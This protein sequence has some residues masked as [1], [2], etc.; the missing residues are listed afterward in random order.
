MRLIARGE[1]QRH[2]GSTPSTK[3]K[4][5]VIHL[6]ALPPEESNRKNRSNA[7]QRTSSHNQPPNTVNATP[8]LA[9]HVPESLSGQSS[10]SSRGKSKT[11]REQQQQN[12]AKK[13]GISSIDHLG[14]VEEDEERDDK[15]S[16]YY[17]YSF[18]HNSLLESRT[19]STE[20]PS[21]VLPKPSPSVIPEQSPY[22]AYEFLKS[23]MNCLDMNQMLKSINDDT[24]AAPGRDAQQEQIFFGNSSSEQRLQRERSAWSGNRLLPDPEHY[25]SH[26]LNLSEHRSTTG[27]HSLTGSLGSPSLQSR[28]GT[29][30]SIQQ[31]QGARV[32]VGSYQPFD[33]QKSLEKQ[34]VELSN[35][36]RYNEYYD[37]SNRTNSLEST[38]RSR[39][40]YM[41]R[42][43]N[44]NVSVLPA[45]SVATSPYSLNHTNSKIEVHTPR[46]AQRRSRNY[47]QQCDTVKIDEGLMC[48]DPNNLK[49]QMRRQMRKKEKAEPVQSGSI[50]SA[51]DLMQMENSNRRKHNKAG[52]GGLKSKLK[53]FFN[54]DAI[55]ETFSPRGGTPKS[56]TTHGSHPYDDNKA[57]FDNRSKA[58]S[59]EAS[60][61]ASSKQ[62]SKENGEGFDQDNYKVSRVLHP[63]V[64]N[65]GGKVFSSADE[66]VSG[67]LSEDLAPVFSESSAGGKQ[68]QSENKRMEMLMPAEGR[69][70]MY[71][72]PYAEEEENENEN[73]NANAK[74]GP[75]ARMGAMARR[76]LHIDRLTAL[77]KDHMGPKAKTKNSS[78]EIVQELGIDIP[79]SPPAPELDGSFCLGSPSL[80][81]IK[82]GSLNQSLTDIL[83]VFAKDREAQ[84]LLQTAPDTNNGEGEGFELREEGEPDGGLVNHIAVSEKET[85]RSKEQAL[86]DAK[87]VVLYSLKNKI[88]QE[89][90]K[91]KMRELQVAKMKGEKT[92]ADIE[93][94]FT[95]AEIMEMF[96]QH[97]VAAKERVDQGDV[98]GGSKDDDKS[99]EE[100]NDSKDVA[101]RKVTFA[102]GSNLQQMQSSYEDDEDD[103]PEI[104]KTKQDF[105]L[106]SWAECGAGDDESY[107]NKNDNGQL[108]TTLTNKTPIQQMGDTAMQTVDLVARNSFAKAQAR[109][110]QFETACV[111]PAAACAAPEQ[112]FED[113]DSFSSG[114]LSGSSYSSSP[115]RT[116]RKASGAPPSNTKDDDKLALVMSYSGSLL[117]GQ[118]YATRDTRDT[119]ADSV[120][121]EETRDTYDTHDSSYYS[122]DDYRDY[123]RR[124]GSSSSRDYRSSSRNQ[125]VSSSR[126]RRSSHRRSSSRRRGPPS[127]ATDYTEYTDDSGGCRV[128]D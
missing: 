13:M 114:I 57:I 74:N 26:N 44:D 79:T 77:A 106:M 35:T 98:G 121:T 125:R 42:N 29:H 104:P 6:R 112:S 102:Q 91:K 124:Y 45:G 16:D 51:T 10:S 27:N 123:R 63:G 37:M 59:K 8:G 32:E 69:N 11:S 107:E 122:R 84:K 70:P 18:G 31:G 64:S 73:A 105:R 14:H 41:T 67:G 81:S 12:A 94:E 96:N 40:S 55:K 9:I 108:Q 116:N 82:L 78:S 128:W 52:G 80:D 60:S 120:F 53:G 39:T 127:V 83:A 54:K 48:V 22:A 90:K 61:K 20:P 68:Q 47:Q 33:I 72:V 7:R 50:I 5:H 75:M 19:R 115:R 110:K 89:L 25:Q 97:L 2:K 66:G 21:G 3:Q 99:G 119:R 103:E 36:S 87:L 58:S 101:R 111:V 23:P 126:N 117:S 15:D 49:Q 118:S 17:R 34:L 71:K 113:E 62:S 28:T 46:R 93:K 86:R 43:F 85:P 1:Q 100:S 88:I 65:V 95:N 38:N 56:Q 92:D 24:M 109:V 4:G 30:D 76:K